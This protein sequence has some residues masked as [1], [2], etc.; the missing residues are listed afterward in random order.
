MV[1]PCQIYMN[2][3]KHPMVYLA[4]GHEKIPTKIPGQ[5]EYNEFFHEEKKL[6]IH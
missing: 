1:G 5:Q 4:I 2:A 6:K 3:Q